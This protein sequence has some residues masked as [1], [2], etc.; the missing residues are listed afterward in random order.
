MESPHDTNRLRDITIAI[1]FIWCIKVR[2][3]S[4]VTPRNLTIE[5]FLRIVSRIFMSNALFWLEIIIYEIS[6]TFRE[7][8]LVLSRL[9][10]P[11]SSL[12]HEKNWK[13][14]NEIQLRKNKM[15]LDNLKISN[16][17]PFPVPYNS[18]NTLYTIIKEL[19]PSL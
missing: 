12:W 1:L 4:S 11:T 15:D 3:T 6:L 8:L 9:S 14:Y 13:K 5:T 18:G 7:S 19:L 16:H 17:P 2:F 10:T